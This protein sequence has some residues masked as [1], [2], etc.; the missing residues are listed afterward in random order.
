MFQ[1]KSQDKFKYQNVYQY[2]KLTASMSPR[3]FQ[4]HPLVMTNQD[5]YATQYLDKSHSKYQFKNAHPSQN[6]YARTS[7][8]SLLTTDI[9]DMVMVT[10]MAIVMDM[11]SIIKR[12]FFTLLV[13][14]SKSQVVGATTKKIA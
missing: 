3:L 10:D 4:D 12:Q 14:P 7:H 11:A 2:P 8:A 9:T 13:V 6:K 1:S 5:K